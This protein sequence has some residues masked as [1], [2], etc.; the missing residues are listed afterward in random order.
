M[1][2]TWGGRGRA[3]RL[4]GAG[5]VQEVFHN[6]V[7][8]SGCWYLYPHRHMNASVHLWKLKCVERKKY[9]RNSFN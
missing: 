5:W 2:L 3:D 4:C 6:Y 8:P 9:F 7:P 1:S